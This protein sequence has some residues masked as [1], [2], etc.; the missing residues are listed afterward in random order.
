MMNKGN[1]GK[2]HNEN[3]DDWETPKRI[4]D[5]LKKQYNFEFDCCALEHNTITKNFSSDFEKIE[6][7]NCICWMNPPFSIAYRM[8]D[9]FFKV[10]EKGVS[11]YRC[12]NM[13][14][15]VWQDIILKNCDWVLIP[16]VAYQYNTELREGKGCR[17]PSAIIGV[18]VEPPVF[19]EGTILYLK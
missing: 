17:F 6:A 18:G 9:H 11:I 1:D 19:Y 2:G 16:K 3:R 15:K 10:V 13:E 14:T 4:I 8:F 7:L 12:D 5:L